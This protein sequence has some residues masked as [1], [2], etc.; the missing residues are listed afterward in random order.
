MSACLLSHNAANVAIPS[1]STL[2]SLCSLLPGLTDV[3]HMQLHLYDLV[4]VR[5]QQMGTTQSLKCTQRSALADAAT[6]TALEG[7][8]AHQQGK[9]NMPVTEMGNSNL[10]TLP[11]HITQPTVA[12][13]NGEPA[14][15]GTCWCLL[16]NA[17]CCA[18]LSDCARGCP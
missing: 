13:Q 5:K 2:L 12:K 10:L 16:I 15:K 18:S 8:P 6:R 1:S 3:C 7:Y 9:E 17:Q 14:N 11:V 4:A